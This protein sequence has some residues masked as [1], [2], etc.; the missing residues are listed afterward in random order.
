MPILALV[1]IVAQMLCAIH[2]AK[3]GRNYYWIYIIIFAPMVGML[4]YFVVEI[5]PELMGSRTARGAAAG[6]G[7]AL[8]PGRA[9]REG[10]KRLA[11]TPTTANK[12]ALA[13]AYLEVGRAEE[14]IALFRDTLVGVHAT[15]PSLM[16]G[17]AR[18]E[19]AQGNFAATE[20][21][22]DALRAAN[23]DFQSPEAH[24]IYARSLEEQN[25]IEGALHEYAALAP[26]Y[27]GQEA[28]CRYAVLLAKAG[29]QIEAQRI[30]REICQSI[31]MSPRHAR[32]LQREWYDIAR[33]ALAA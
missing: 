23:P 30:F 13:E 31:E 14:A 26:Y 22:L 20:Q 28:R 4:A 2:V 19:F 18:A 9:V 29:Q 15:D 17:L 11:M 24:L 7:R 27:P 21:T 25:K 33:R 16:F 1:E 8:N 10:E 3:T 6:V 12:V 32:R 5:L